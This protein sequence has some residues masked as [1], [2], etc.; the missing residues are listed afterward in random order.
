[1][2]K[3]MMSLSVGGILLF[4]S[5][6]GAVAF[7]E[8]M[9]HDSDGPEMGDRMGGRMMGEHMGRWGHRGGYGYGARREM[10]KKRFFNKLKSLGLLRA[11]ANDDGIITW[12]EV[13]KARGQ[14]FARFD[15][16]KDGDITKEEIE[17]HLRKRME[18]RARVITSWF[19]SNGDGKISKDEFNQSA[20]ERFR[21]KDFNEDNQ[22]SG[23]ELPRR[24]YWQRRMREHMRGYSN[25]EQKHDASEKT[26]GMAEKS[27]DK[28]D[29]K[30]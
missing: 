16:N 24:F 26:D 30:G 6:A 23:R 11:D 10:R 12:E 18:R 28:T 3:L 29:K 22:L 14:Y 13:E 25:E 8:R 19:D 5:I 15:T 7:D 20:K 4:T 17:A 21:W 27:T 9:G 2:S 1:M